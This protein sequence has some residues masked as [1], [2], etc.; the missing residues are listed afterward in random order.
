M[1]KKQTRILLLT[2]LIAV[3]LFFLIEKD[4][5]PGISTKNP[6]DKSLG[7]LRYVIS[8]IKLDYHKEPDPVKT[9]EGAL[10]GLVGPLD[11]ISGY[12]DSENAVKFI[13]QRKTVQK[14]IGIVLYKKFGTFP[15]V[16]GIRENS[17][18]EKKGIKIGELISALDGKPTLAMSMTEA[19]LLLKD[20]EERPVELK[21]L[22]SDKTEK[23]S[24]ERK[25]LFEEPF[26][27]SP[28]KDTSGILKIY[29]LYPP[30]VTKIKKDIL[31]RL[32][33]QKKALILDLRNCYEGGIGEAVKL[34]N[35][36]IQSENIGYFEKK[37]GTKEVISCPEEADL[38]RLPLVI[39]TNRATIG[40]AEAVAAVLKEFKKAKII[41]FQT[42]GLIAKQKFL[43]LEDGSGLLLTSEIFFLASGKELWLKGIKPDILIQKEHLGQSSYLKNT[44]EL[45]PK[46]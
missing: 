43:L 32:K 28:A 20:S 33:P 27:Y 40:P 22:R 46:M 15:Q 26:S 42:P 36:F 35:L 37:G 2:V 34:I 16:I 24:I 31:P 23:V 17:P 39:W 13:Q 41:G 5:L 7:I 21:M 19:N 30:C 38:G 9:M 44:Y 1:A 25:L 11:I 6:T 4:F 12:L 29:R 14:D 45:L 3:S 10:K 8:R 18:A